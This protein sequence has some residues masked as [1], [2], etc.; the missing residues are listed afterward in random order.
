MKFE[1]QMTKKDE[2]T[3]LLKNIR[4]PIEFIL[5]YLQSSILFSCF[6]L[7]STISLYPSPYILSFFDFIWIIIT[8][9]LDIYKI[10]IK[11]KRKRLLSNIYFYCEW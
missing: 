9:Q 2:Q 8:N 1:Y 10:I 3:F 7:P 6:P 4:K 5:L 11:D